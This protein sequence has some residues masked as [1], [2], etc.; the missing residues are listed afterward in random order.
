MEEVKEKPFPSFKNE[1]L[2]LEVDIWVNE[3]LEYIKD[4]G[5]TEEF[6]YWVKPQI[7][8]ACITAMDDHGW[9]YNGA[10]EGYTYKLTFYS[11]EKDLDEWEH[12]AINFWMKNGEI[13][14]WVPPEE[15]KHIIK[16]M[17][18][19]GFSVEE[20]DDGSCKFTAIEMEE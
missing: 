19:N 6:S 16:R 5:I 1:L 7:M 20:L 18:R 8:E 10:E 4:N 3:V 2:M 9:I 12:T 14:V 17:K 11:R 15:K 13:T